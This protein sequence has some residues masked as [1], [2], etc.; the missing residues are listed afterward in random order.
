MNNRFRHLPT[1]G[2][3][4]GLLVTSHTIPADAL[5]VTVNG[6]RNTQGDVVVCVWRAQDKG[7]PNCGTGRPWKKLAAPAANPSVA[8]GDIP[9]E[10]I[11]VSMFHDEQRTGK[12]QTNFLGMPTSGVGLANNPDIGPMNRPTFDKARVVPGA[13][14]IEITAKYLF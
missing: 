13:K 3:L 7:F 10:A 8:F 6:L 2:L 5:D 9:P 4:A 12:P 14:A 11:A 1:L